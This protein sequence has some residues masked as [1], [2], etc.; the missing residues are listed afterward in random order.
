MSRRKHRHH[1]SP[2]PRSRSRTRP[3]PTC[4]ARRPG[5]RGPGLLRRVLG[6]F[7]SGLAAVLVK[8]V[9]GLLHRD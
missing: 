7:A 4:A 5:P 3:R 2:R 1:P 9:M 6:A 8:E